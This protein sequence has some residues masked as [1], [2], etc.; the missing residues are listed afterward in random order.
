MV[1]K[2]IQEAKD[3]LENPSPK[4]KEA[5]EKLSKALRLLRRNKKK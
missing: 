2:E 1:E 3:L 4:I 5:G